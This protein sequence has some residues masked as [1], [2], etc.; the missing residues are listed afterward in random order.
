M[1]NFFNQ[2]NRD[3]IRELVSFLT[4]LFYALNRNSL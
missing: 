1:Y 3:K 4:I 2:I